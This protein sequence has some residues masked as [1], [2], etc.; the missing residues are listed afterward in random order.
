MRKHPQYA[1]DMLSAISYL[2]PALDIPLYHH[3]RWNGSGYPRGLKGEDIPKIARL[4]AIIDVWD[5]LSSDRPYRKKLPRSE[6]VAYLRENASHLFDPNLVEVF[7]S[8]IESEK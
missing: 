4:F 2:H 6:V 5:A 7:L 8:V 3:E 1:N